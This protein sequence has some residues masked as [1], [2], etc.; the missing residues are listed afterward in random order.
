M[1]I[2]IPF[3]FTNLRIK[4]SIKIPSDDE[5]KRIAHPSNS[6]YGLCMPFDEIVT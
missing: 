4:E 5:M 3:I 1:F 2:A 6:L